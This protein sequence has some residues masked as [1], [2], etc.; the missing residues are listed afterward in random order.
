MPSDDMTF[1]PVAFDQPTR[2]MLLPHVPSQLIRL[3]LDD[4]LKVEAMPDK[5][6]VNMMIY[7]AP[8]GGICVVCL[9]GAAI[10]QTLRAGF[11]EQKVP[12]DY[13]GHNERAIDFLS[14]C[15]LGVEMDEPYHTIDD[16]GARPLKANVLRPSYSRD[17]DGFHTAMRALADAFEAS[18]Q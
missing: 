1:A 11:L 18:G 7:H 8:E 12:Q 2:E 5:Y 6:R 17:R 10:A 14:S 9:A 3:A 15:A 4:L 13:D 16:I